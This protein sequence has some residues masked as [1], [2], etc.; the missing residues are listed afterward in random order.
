MELQQG[1]ISIKYELRAKKSSVKRAICGRFECI[2]YITID[3]TFADDLICIDYT[4]EKVP[5]YNGIQPDNQHIDL[6]NCHSFLVPLPFI[7]PLHLG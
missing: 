6:I 2:A 4:A 1:R 5:F 7:I 3:T